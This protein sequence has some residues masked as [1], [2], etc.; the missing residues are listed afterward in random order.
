[1]L[2][3]RIRTTYPYLHKACTVSTR[4]ELTNVFVFRSW[5]SWAAPRLAEP[6]A[7]LSPRQYPPLLRQVPTYTSRY[8]TFSPIFHY[9]STSPIFVTFL[10]HFCYECVDKFSLRSNDIFG[11]FRFIPFSIL[12]TVFFYLPLCCRYVCKLRRSY[13]LLTVSLMIGS[14]VPTV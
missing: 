14:T 10:H 8:I 5:P 11:T 9:R 6:T 2:S 4:L 13:F 7:R 1:M 3:I 12:L